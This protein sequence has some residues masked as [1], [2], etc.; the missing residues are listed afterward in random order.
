MIRAAHDRALEDEGRLFA[1]L[2]AQYVAGRATLALPARP[3]RGAR[4]AKIEARILQV[5]L[6]R[7]RNGLVEDLPK[8]IEVTLLD[9]RESN[10]PAGVPAVHWRLITTRSV[11]DAADAFAVAAL[12]RRRWAIEQL[13]RT[14][15]SDGFDIERALIEAEAA[16][17]KLIMATLIAAVSVQRLVHA[18]EGIAEDGSIRPL[19][20][21]FEPEDA[22]VV[23]VVRRLFFSVLLL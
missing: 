13:F 22:A 5:A 11:C 16:L 8:S 14:L 21:A 7:P 19:T 12:Y 9:I 10:P 1:R 3:G 6:Q 18:R 4:E 15:K 20:D 17:R 23:A 2:D